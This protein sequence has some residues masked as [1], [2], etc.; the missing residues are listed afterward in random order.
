MHNWSP[1]KSPRSSELIVNPDQIES[2]LSEIELA[3]SKWKTYEIKFHSEKQTPVGSLAAFRCLATVTFVCLLMFLFFSV[4][5]FSPPAI[6]PT[7]TSSSSGFSHGKQP[8]KVDLDSILYW[9]VFAIFIHETLETWMKQKW[10]AI[11]KKR[12]LFRLCLP[13]MSSLHSVIFFFKS[14]VWLYVL[15]HLHPHC[16]GRLIPQ[17][18]P[19][20]I[21]G[22]PRLRQLTCKTPESASQSAIPECKHRTLK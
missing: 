15:H 2:W 7:Q 22:L 11:K 17:S 3:S 6:N 12:T 5:L 16:A 1:L 8:C 21:P 14:S 18:V 4:L 10:K 13:E 9:E 19:Q 20:Q